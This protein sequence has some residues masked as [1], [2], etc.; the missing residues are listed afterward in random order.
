MLLLFFYCTK[1]V[2]SRANFAINITKG[3]LLLL[4]E[5]GELK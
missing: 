2:E 5:R 4:Q 3:A 1:E